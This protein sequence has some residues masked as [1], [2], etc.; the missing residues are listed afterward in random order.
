MAPHEYKRTEVAQVDKSWSAAGVDI[1]GLIERICAFDRYVGAKLKLI[2]AMGL[3]KKEAVML[4]PHRCT[5]PFE[6]TGIDP[7]DR[8]ADEYVLIKSGAKGGRAR[9]IPLNTPERIAALEYARA[10]IEDKDGHMGDPDKRLHQ[11]M[12]RFDYVMFKFGIARKQ[13]GVTV[14]GLRHEAMIEHYEKEAGTPPPVRGG[15]PPSPEKDDAAR[16]SAANLAGHARISAAGAYLGPMIARREALPS[17][18]RRAEQKN[19]Q[20]GDAG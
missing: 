6:A 17:R 16:L 10:V 11:N 1:D 3:R 9:Y 2:R 4:R 20:G 19:A 12:R 15:V 8:L 18:G 7:L 13:L 5:V 14:H